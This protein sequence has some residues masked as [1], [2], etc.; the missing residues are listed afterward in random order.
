MTKKSFLKGA[1]ILGVAGILI[2]ILGAI[3]RIPL[4]NLL[5]TEGMGYYQTSYPVYNTLYAISTAGIPVA[6]AKIIAEKRALG[7]YK[8]AK[9]A[10]YLSLIGLMIFGLCAS[11]IVT[12]FGR[13][14]SISLENPKAYYALMA[15]IP[16]LLFA[17]MTSAFRGY[18]QG[19]QEMVPTALSQILEQL[20]RVIVGYSLA[21]ILISD[22]LDKAAGG[23][24]FGAS[25]GAVAAF[26]VVFYIY[27]IKRK[28][29]DCEIELQHFESNE[30]TKSLIKK[31]LIIALPIALG[32][33]IVPIMN[34]I[35]VKLIMAKLQEIGYS[36][37]EANSMLGQMT[38]FA[39]TFI[40]FPQV[41]AISLAMSLV[42]AVSEAYALK[43]DE[44]IKSI[45]NGGLRTIIMIG[46]P[47]AFGLFIMSNPII[48]LLYY[49]ISEVEQES[50][51]AILACLSFSVIFLTII[52]ALT[53]LLQGVG[54]M[55]VPVINL[56]IGG[57]IKLT[58]S[59]VLIGI[60]GLNIYGA[61][62]STIVFYMVAALL[63]YIAVKKYLD[64]EFDLKQVFM[65]PFLATIMMT[66]A[67]WVSYNGLVYVISPKIAT[68]IA[69]LVAILIYGL[70]IIGLKAITSEEIQ[71]I[72]KGDKIL[73]VL[74]KM[75]L[76]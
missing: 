7:D 65:K 66:L 32:A 76:I 8:S 70:F 24:T 31:I 18:F 22:G 9:K 38:G 3:Y 33:I 6:V 53:A 50:I 72:P 35:D 75:K 39:Q 36:E 5:T 16:A 67:A 11:G 46:F 45:A 51:G 2:K 19:H 30:T 63:D 69:I 74:K 49:K 10:F 12:F 43:D 13:E 1:A 34:M 23:A 28:R 21:Y 64:V 59:Y 71:S 40:N 48:K 54:K 41:L 56:I 61:V 26:L 62:I 29:L 68:I 57:F 14:I 55:I 27:L 73:R 47:A 20:V 42:P 58:L 15:M 25:A 60:P 44:R 17:P 4:G 52:Q 37:L